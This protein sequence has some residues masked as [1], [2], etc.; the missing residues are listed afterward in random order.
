MSAG[1]SCAYGYELDPATAKCI[2]KYPHCKKGFTLNKQLT[3]CIPLPTF[4][5]PFIF[6]YAAAIWTFLVMIK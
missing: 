1:I 5:M 2:L 6:L 3:E 4:H